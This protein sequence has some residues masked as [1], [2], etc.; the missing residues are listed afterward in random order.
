MEQKRVSFKVAKALKEAGYPQMSKIGYREGE[1]LISYQIPGV[2]FYVI[3]TY[4]DVWLWLWREKGIKT[5]IDMAHNTMT[6][7]GK[8]YWLTD[9]NS[10]PEDA[11]IAAIDHLVNN[12]LIK[13][14]MDHEIGTRIT[15][16]VM[17]SK[18][19]SCKG[20]YFEHRCRE[21]RRCRENERTDHKNI[22]YKAIEEKTY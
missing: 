9:N 22:I 3:P 14:N 5:S 20:C 17:E 10:D 4:L 18:E 13:K 7:I 21:Y 8:D 11:I 19:G 6:N 1:S 2:E 15:L 16:E 12:N